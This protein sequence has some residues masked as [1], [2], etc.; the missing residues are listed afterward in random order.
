MILT[1][2]A[3]N[4]RAISWIAYTSKVGKEAKRR[5]KGPFAGETR[6]V[7]LVF[8]LCSDKAYAILKSSLP[9]PLPDMHADFRIL[10][11]RLVASLGAISTAQ[12]FYIPGEL[13]LMPTRPGNASHEL[14]LMPLS[15]QGGQSEAT[16]T[17]KL[18]HCTSTKSTQTIPNC[19]MPITTCPSFAHRQAKSTLDMPAGGV[20]PLIWARYFEGTGS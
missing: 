7:F 13:L 14:M 11:C 4:A 17:M 19:N 12:S 9:P 3:S 20:S 1:R 6:D 10:L 18:F 16:S 15:E 2:V 5:Y 8:T